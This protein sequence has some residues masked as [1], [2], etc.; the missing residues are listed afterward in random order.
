MRFNLLT[1]TYSQ[2][3]KYSK[4]M[5][6]SLM[7]AIMAVIM[8]WP[9]QLAAAEAA[10]GHGQLELV[11]DGEAQAVVIV[12]EEADEQTTAAAQKLVDY[13]QQATGAEL[14]LMTL[15][16]LKASGQSLNGD[17]RIYVGP[18]EQWQSPHL[19]QQLEGLDDDGFVIQTRGNKVFIT[20][21]TAWGTE[22]G[23]ND[24]LERYVGVRWL[25]PGP[26]GTHVP[27]LEDLEVPRNELIREEPAAF[28]RLFSPLQKPTGSAGELQHEWARNNRMHS[29]IEFH[30]NLH[31]LF[32]VEEY[33]ET[34]PEFYP[35]GQ[36][37]ISDVAW[38]PCFTADGIVEEGISNIITYF[39]ENPD[40]S[41]YSL[42]VNDSGGYC[43][44]NPAHPD[45]PDELNSVGVQNISNI[46]YNWVNQVVEGVLEV[47]PDKW[48]GLLAYSNVF[49]PPT[50]VTLHE[51]VVPFITDDRYAWVDSGIEQASKAVVE[52]WSEKATSLGFYE[53]M[54]GSPYA[55][56]RVYLEQMADNYRYGRD[57]G[58]VAHYAELYPNWGEGPKPY[59]SLK[60]QWNP[61]LDEEQ[62]AEDWYEAMVGE[63]A[64]PYLQQYYEQWEEIWT[65][66]VPTST[67]FRSWAD[68]TTRANYLSFHDASYLTVM[69]ADDVAESRALLENMQSLTETDAQAARAELLMKTFQYYEASV[70]SYPSAVDI[71][72]PQTEQEALALLE[73]GLVRMANA[74]ERMNI[75]A[76]HMNDPILKHL[77]TAERFGLVW[78][79][80]SDLMMSYLSEW[81]AGEDENGAVTAEVQNIMATTELDVVRHN[82]ELLLAVAKGQATDMA[83][84]S[85]EDGDAP[86]W[87]WI[88]AQGALERSELYAR[89]GQYS[90]VADG[91]ARGG[92][93]QPVP[94]SGG[95]YGVALHYYTPE[96]TVN[97]ASIQLTLNL[98]DENGGAVTTLRA[99][100][101]P[102]STVP[103]GQWGMMQHVFHIPAVYNGKTVAQAQFVATIN[104][105]EEGNQLYIDD[106]VSV[107]L[108][109]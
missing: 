100:S 107:P 80:L 28:S 38:Q 94:V 83:N 65:E 50:E 7:A 76:E 84:S 25:I 36:V 40:A 29:R 47:H 54:Y 71:P 66:R 43:E 26:D 56:P 22:F 102:V 18:G 62:L 87:F 106:I 108:Q 48:F 59:I 32:P 8:L 97:N 52:G 13:I 11:E 67:W 5:L 109:P 88:K 70:L 63:E 49:D 79:G 33:G 15:Y 90:I 104:G 60:L 96:G 85:F 72:Q 19:Q 92:P 44:S 105:V 81:I 45:F 3:G 23:V 78:S 51:R 16:D 55:T 64:A 42:G 86:W 39:N 93:V 75:I 98:K 101:L 31:N 4:G 35:G 73:D 30:H 57:Q 77:L 41:S 46:Y 53:Y 27:E 91:L 21:P 61:D 69:T 99:A 37:P 89:T 103:S 24:F 95:P 74:V 17:A 58:V 10:V 82:L 12:D 20:G 68:A 2:K 14:P 1:S 6:A 34:H 9:P